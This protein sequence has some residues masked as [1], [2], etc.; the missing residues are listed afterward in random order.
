MLLGERALPWRQGSEVGWWLEQ[1]STS[2][3]MMVKRKSE[4]ERVGE[5][6]GRGEREDEGEMTR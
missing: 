6:I 4:D 1:R 2:A 3:V 5:W